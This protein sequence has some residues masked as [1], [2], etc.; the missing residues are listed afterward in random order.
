MPWLLLL[1]A[2]NAHSTPDMR[3]LAC[4]QVRRG[5]WSSPLM[6]VG[7]KLYTLYDGTQTLSGADRQQPQGGRR[8]VLQAGPSDGPAPQ[9]GHKPCFQVVAG[10][11]VQPRQPSPPMQCRVSRC[12]PT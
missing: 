1:Q 3:R 2:P 4:M 10:R 8:F 12:H 7:P 9:R 6:S 11:T 5:L